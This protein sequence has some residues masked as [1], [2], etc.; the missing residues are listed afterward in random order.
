MIHWRRGQVRA[1]TGGW[2][3][4]S[5]WEVALEDGAVLPA[6]A[7]DSLTGAPRPGDAVLLNITALR[8]GLGTGGHALV[9]ALPDR[10]PE[11]AVGPGGADPAGHIV[12]ARYTP[13]QTMVLALEE[14]ESPWHE[15]MTE[16]AAAEGDL[17]GMPV[18]AAE[19]H[20]A[21]PA[22]LAGVRS[23]RPDARVVYVMTDTGALPMALSRT[24]AT[25]REAGV[26]HA[27]ITAGQA[28]GGEHEAITVHSALLAARHVLGADIAVVAQGPGNAGSGTPWGFSG[29]GHGEVLN[30]A[31]TLRG[32]GIAALRVSG[33]DPRGR[34]RGLSHHAW[35]ALARVLLGAADLAI[36]DDET[37]LPG[38]T[39]QV[40]A[41][42]ADAAGAPR[43][44]RVRSAGLDQA[45]AEL[46]VPMTTMGRDRLRD[47]A[48]FVVAAAAGRHAAGLLPSPLSRP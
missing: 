15:A 6:L 8:K 14:Q 7:Y 35:A 17:G 23:H 34:H 2:G 44:V 25:L 43:M 10:L 20:S 45:L 46:P 40:E 5:T 33:A 26:L 36:P 24:V 21:L 13:Q 42:C 41:L 47:P 3:E 37:V 12:K 18:V 29:I 39:E 16:G 19:L 31:H 11:D 32:R 27:T 30:A 4:A 9:I 28:F 1:R 38:L 22:I 48:P